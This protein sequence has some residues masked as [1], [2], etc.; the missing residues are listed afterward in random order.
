MIKNLLISVSVV[1]V[2]FLTVNQIAIN[3]YDGQFLNNYDRTK[4]KNCGLY[5]G[6]YIPTKTTAKIKDNNTILLKNAWA[7]K[8]WTITHYLL[9]FEKVKVQAGLNLLIPDTTSFFKK[10][11]SFEPFDKSIT[12][13]GGVDNAGE[14][15]SF[16][17]RADTIKFLIKC[18][19][20][21]SWTET[22]ITDT[23]RYVRSF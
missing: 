17:E 7:E 11:Y 22:V 10:N 20:A 12:K 2:V 13:E 6:E 9:F 14:T 5:L 16:D 18:K 21:E 15:F 3:S 8:Q 23:I 4:S 1:I 19:K